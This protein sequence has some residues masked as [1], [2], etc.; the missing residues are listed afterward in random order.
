VASF[1]TAI[2]ITRT[3]FLVYLS[4]KKTADPISI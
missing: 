3:L 4:G 1:F 2:Y